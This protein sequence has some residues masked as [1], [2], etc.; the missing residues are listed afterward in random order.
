VLR[1]GTPTQLLIEEF[2]SFL[3]RNYFSALDPALRRSIF[4]RIDHP[5]PL[6]V[7]FL[8]G[9]N[10]PFWDAP[11]DVALRF[12]SRL[13]DFDDNPIPDCLRK[14]RT[15]TEQDKQFGEKRGPHGTSS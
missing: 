5:E 8:D 11:F 14:C 15:G 3:E 10:I 2:E 7:Y 4:T 9:Q 1:S 13:L 6:V 12:Q